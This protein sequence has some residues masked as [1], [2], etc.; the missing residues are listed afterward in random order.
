MVAY[1]CGVGF[2]LFTRQSKFIVRFVPQQLLI[3]S[4]SDGKTGPW[5]GLLA[6]RFPGTSTDATAMGVQAMGS[7]DQ[8]EIEY[9]SGVC[10]VEVDQDNLTIPSR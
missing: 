5:L 9:G 4:S 2:P 7:R 8:N 3:E 1:V 10:C 6:I